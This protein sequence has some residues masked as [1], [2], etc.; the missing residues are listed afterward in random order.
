MKKNGETAED[1]IKF[2]NRMKMEFF[3]GIGGLRFKCL[4]ERKVP[5]DFS[6]F[7]GVQK[8][9]SMGV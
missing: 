7:N 3:S 8:F 5:L 2:V 1:A 6:K 9:N 4:A